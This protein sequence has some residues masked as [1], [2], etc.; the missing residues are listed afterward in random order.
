MEVRCEMNRQ[1]TV[2]KVDGQYSLNNGDMATKLTLQI[3]HG[4]AT[5]WVTADAVW[6]EWLWLLWVDYSHG[7][8]C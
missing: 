3:G 4:V 2:I 7:C 5:M 8:V 6:V 1:P